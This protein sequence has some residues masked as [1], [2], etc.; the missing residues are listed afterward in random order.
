MRRFAAQGGIE[1]L[2]GGDREPQVAQRS[3]SRITANK[4][5]AVNSS[6]CILGRLTMASGKYRR[7]S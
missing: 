4:K 7:H 2:S 5:S 1:R 3:E 6:L